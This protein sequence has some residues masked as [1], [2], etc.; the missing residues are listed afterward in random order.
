MCND[1]GGGGPSPTIIRSRG[2]RRRRRR[3]NGQSSCSGSSLSSLRATHT[4]SP[5][6]RDA[7]ATSP[8]VRLSM[9]EKGELYELDLLEEKG[10]LDEL[11]SAELSFLRR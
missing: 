7:I 5:R 4:P 2:A 6:S 8:V 1:R 9:L 10:E 3:K 11:V